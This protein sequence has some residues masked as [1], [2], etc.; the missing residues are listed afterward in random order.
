[1][2]ALKYNIRGTEMN[3]LPF[4]EI[5][6]YLQEKGLDVMSIF[7][8]MADEREFVYVSNGF[9]RGLRAE[10]NEVGEWHHYFKKES[11]KNFT[12][13]KLNFNK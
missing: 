10:Q 7:Y 8:Q 5:E 3:K 11:D 1:M 2:N 6:P 4:A 13:Y 12:A 9:M